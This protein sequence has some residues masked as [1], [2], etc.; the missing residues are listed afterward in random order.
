MEQELESNDIKEKLIQWKTKSFDLKDKLNQSKK[1]IERLDKLPPLLDMVVSFLPLIF[2]VLTM[3]FIFPE[4]I[5]LLKKLLNNKVLVFFIGLPI[6]LS[7]IGY[8]L[9]ESLTEKTQKKF[10][11]W[12]FKKTNK[13]EQ[14][15]PLENDLIHI[16]QE[17]EKLLF[18]NELMQ[19]LKDHKPELDEKDCRVFYA[20]FA[21]FK[22]WTE[23]KDYSQA[24]TSLGQMLNYLLNND[25]LFE[26]KN[27]LIKHL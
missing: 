21:S 5:I 22:T 20:N 27:K 10:V 8:S 9:F 15:T 26:D 18:N 7:I 17:I 12:Y 13:K 2:F 6:G 14:K 11:K 4:I 23:H 25:H 19:I 24:C 1:D 16:E 3:F